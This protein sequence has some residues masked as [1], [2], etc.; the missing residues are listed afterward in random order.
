MQNQI[1]SHIT[2]TEFEDAYWHRETLSAF[3][4]AKE[5]PSSGSKITLTGR[6]AAFLRGAAPGS[7][8]TPKLAKAKIPET[9]TPNTVIG[10]NW[11]CSQQLRH[12]FTDHTKTRFHFSKEIRDFIATGAGKTLQDALDHWDATRTNTQK[13]PIEPQFEYNRFMRAFH[14]QNPGTGHQAAVTAWK[15]HRDTRISERS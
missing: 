4:R 2:V 10:P 15:A 9:L 12:F 7:T 3:C 13:R 5:L 11:P 6:I 1:P 8:A 14:S